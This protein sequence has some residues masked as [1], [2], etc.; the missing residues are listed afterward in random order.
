MKIMFAVAFFL[1]CMCALAAPMMD[2]AE[3]YHADIPPV[4]STPAGLTQ[5]PSLEL[6]YSLG[7]REATQAEIAADAAAKAS[8]ASA[9]QAEADAQAELPMQSAT[10]FAALDEDGHWVEL[11]PTGDGLP[12]IGVQVSNSPLTAEQREQMKAQRKAA[13]DALKAKAK[14]AKTDKEKLAVLMKAVFGKDAQ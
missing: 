13:H 3:N 9:A 1:S 11:L 6:L 12:V 14:A 4:V 10:G 5:N 7:W 2:D 8:A